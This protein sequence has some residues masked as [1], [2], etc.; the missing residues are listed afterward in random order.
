MGTV[1][2]VRITVLPTPDV[3]APTDITCCNG[4]S[5]TA[6]TF[7]GNVTNTIFKWTNSNTNIGLAASGK[8]NI[9]SFTST[10]SST[11]T[12]SATISVTPYTV[13]PNGIDDNG[14]GDDC[15]GTAQTFTITVLPTPDVTAPTDAT[16]CNGASTTAITFSGNVT[17][18]SLIHI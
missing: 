14:S 10:N 7:S 13:G 6:I 15:V 4:A 16:Y 5:T 17:G 9:A 1:Q 2:T 11:S 18:L 12:I 3:T 8:G